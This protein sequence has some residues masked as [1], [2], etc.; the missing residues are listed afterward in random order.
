MRGIFTL[1]LLKKLEEVAG[2]PIYEWADMVAGTSTG[3]IISGL[4]AARKSAVEIEQ[5]YIQLVSR[6]FTKRGE[7][8]NRFY[9][10]PAFDKKNYR[11]MLKSIFGDKTL[12]QLCLDN[13]PDML[14][15]AKDLAAGEETF[16]VCV[17]NG[18]TIR[19]IYRTALIRGVL[20]ATM[21]A[22]TYFSPF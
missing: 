21:S 20:E 16:F 3:A 22:P 2:A 18:G 11:E 4:I 13:G 19:N 9:N 6:V 15:T 12:E 7:L 17:N 10:P 8:S 5:L 14:F 1:Q